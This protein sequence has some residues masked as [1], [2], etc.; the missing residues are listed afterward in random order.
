[1][2]NLNSVTSK[3]VSSGVYEFELSSLHA[4]INV[5]EC[6]LHIA[7]RLDFKKW[8]AREECH[9][10]MLKS[11]KKLIQDKFNNELN[12]L[13]DIVKQGSGTTNDGNTARRFFEF[14]DKIA[15]IT[16]L[17][18]NLIRRFA[19]I[20]QA[21]T[22]G[23]IIDVPKFKEYAKITAEKYV[24]LYNWYYMSSTVHKLLIHGGDNRRKCY[25]TNW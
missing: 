21:I 13:V 18:E 15:A 8:S 20:L 12:L 17:N 1:M 3:T 14:P 4:C 11:R 24:E 7:Y 19:V 9:K 5:M 22:F 23:E 10:Q 2:N 6:L 25:C 16:G